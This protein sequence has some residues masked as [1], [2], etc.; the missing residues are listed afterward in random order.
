MLAIGSAMFAMFYFLSLYIQQVLHFSP[1]KAG[2]AFLPF[3]IGIVVAAQIASTLV[4]RVDPRWIAGTGAAVAAVGMLWLTQLQ[5]DS[6]YWTHLVGPIVVL[7]VGLG[8]AFVPLTLTAVMGVEKRDS[9]VASAVLNTTQQIGGA[10]G[11]ATLSTVATSAANHRG[12]DLG[13]ALQQQVA[14][15]AVS[16]DQLPVQQ[17]LIQL[18][19]FTHGATTAF[20][21]GAAMMVAGALIVFVVLRVRHR[22]LAAD[23]VQAVVPEEPGVDRL[24]DLDPELAPA[25]V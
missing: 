2:L 17:L 19:S 7:A 6:G 13:A 11:L 1:F 16:Q 14:S 18:T 25:E 4:S 21:S 24:T 12:A 8:L 10:L 22:E 23:G 5:V 3:S 15:G 20:A 9:G